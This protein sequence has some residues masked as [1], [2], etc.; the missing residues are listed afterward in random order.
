MSNSDSGVQLG[1]VDGGETQARPKGYTIPDFKAMHASQAAQSALRRSQLAPTVPVPIAF[2]TDMR[3]KERELFDERLREKEREME[4]AREVQ[5]R[6]REEEEA[7]ELREL[8]KRAIPKAHEVP[9]WYKEAPRKNHG[10]GQ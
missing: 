8:R 9:E 5:R 2:N 4:A 7:K 6:E 1:G 3:A 10:A